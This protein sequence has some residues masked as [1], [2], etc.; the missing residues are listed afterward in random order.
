M[1]HADQTQPRESA[2]PGRLGFVEKLAYGAGDLSSNLMW[3]MT[4]SYLMYYYTD[5]YRLPA[6][7]VAWVLLIPRSLD[8]FLDPL[9]GYIIDRTSGKYVKRWI[10]WLAVPFGIFAFACFLPLPLSDTGKFIW[11]LLTYIVFG[12]VYSGINTPYGVLSTMMTNTPQ[13]R[14]NLNAF[15]MVG[16]QSGQLIIAALTLPAARFLAG[17]DDLTHRQFGFAAYCGILSVAG[18]LL[19]IVTARNTHIR[20]PFPSEKHKL[21]TL[22]S[23]LWRNGHW[24]V[25]N[26]LTFMN[27][28][29]FCSE[30]GLAIHYTRFVLHRPASDAALL[31][32]IATASAVIGAMLVPAL[33]ARF[34]VRPSFSIL[35]VFQLL[36]FAVMFAAG[37]H[38]AVFLAAFALQ[39]LGVGA[40]SPLCYTL[41]GEAIDHGRESNGIAAAGLAYS[42]NT[43]VSKVAVGATGFALA[44]LLVWG[45]Y[46]PELAVQ[47]PELTA[48][49]KFGFIGLPSTA[50]CVALAALV[51]STTMKRP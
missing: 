19:W 31:L 35:L 14:V 3:G 28:I 21:S 42:I 6:A 48:W 7:T 49:L 26:I 5:I 11:A 13:E 45:H 20:Q 22:L 46:A 43:L 10:G 23:A 40:V 1:S 24:H 33:T 38:F 51:Y 8:A 25:C 47:S 18:A 9:C 36:N 27:F 41:L 4:L 32:T 2:G 39:S 16:C 15:R 44:S 17:G 34:K 50:I 30:Y 37:D 12:A 29:V